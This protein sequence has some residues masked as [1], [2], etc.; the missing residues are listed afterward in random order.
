[1]KNSSGDSKFILAPLMQMRDDKLV[2]NVDPGRLGPHTNTAATIEGVPDLSSEQATALD[3]LLDS[4]KRNE[5]PVSLQKGDMLFVNNWAIMHRRE[6]YEDGDTTS[7]HLVRIW[8]RN[9]RLGWAIPE[10]MAVPWKASFERE[11]IKKVYNIH[12]STE[13]QIPKYSAGSAAFVID[14]I[15]EGKGKE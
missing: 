12:P 2:T 14:D 15:E 4:A 10:D 6:S 3:A 11:G 9:T 8:L 13:Y 7:R 1:D 5:V